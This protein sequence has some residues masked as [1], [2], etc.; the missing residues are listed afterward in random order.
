MTG[1]CATLQADSKELDRED[2][3]VIA[4]KVGERRQVD[5]GKGN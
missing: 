5:A 1:G 2:V 4:G 3:F